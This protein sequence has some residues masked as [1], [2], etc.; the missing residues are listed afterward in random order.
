MDDIAQSQCVL[1]CTLDTDTSDDGN[2]QCTKTDGIKI[3][4]ND[5]SVN[6]FTPP[7]VWGKSEVYD[8]SA[9]GV[10]GRYLMNMTYT[11][12]ETHMAATAQCSLVPITAA[13]YSAPKRPFFSERKN[14]FNLGTPFM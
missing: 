3:T 5:W 7:N 1:Y 12:I 13:L 9:P 6:Y 11:A 8:A 2:R 14:C 10:D 4:D